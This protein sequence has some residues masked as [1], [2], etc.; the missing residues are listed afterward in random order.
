ME[1]EEASHDLLAHFVQEENRTF[2][3]L[4]RRERVG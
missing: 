3:S 2:L 1:A 4:P